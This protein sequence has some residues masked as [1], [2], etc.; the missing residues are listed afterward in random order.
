MVGGAAMNCRSVAS[1]SRR[2]PYPRLKYPVEAW[3]SRR[4]YVA[5]VVVVALLAATVWGLVEYGH[6]LAWWMIPYAIVAAL[7]L[8]LGLVECCA[9]WV[10]GCGWC[11][12]SC[13]G[14][15]QTV[16]YACGDGRFEEKFTD[17]GPLHCV[18]HGRNLRDLE[19][20]GWYYS[21]PRNDVV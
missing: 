3:A 2:H 15:T 16:T 4:P 10:F 11:D 12:Y 21:R 18:L 1:R 5:A 6:L 8:V 9:R 14:F 17:A 20:C 19:P 13:G 7:F